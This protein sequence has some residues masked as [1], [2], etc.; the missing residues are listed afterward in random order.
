MPSA[1][2]F[3]RADPAVITAQWITDSTGAMVSARRRSAGDRIEPPIS[4]NRPGRAAKSRRARSGSAMRS[5]PTT[6]L[7]SVSRCSTTLSA[8]K[9]AA[10]VIRMAMTLETTDGHG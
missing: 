4:V 7:P 2:A 8:T 9:P 10:P 5:S 6:S 3:S 1:S